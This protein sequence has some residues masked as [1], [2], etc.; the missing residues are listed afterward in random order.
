MN[1]IVTFIFLLCFLLMFSSTF[2][3]AGALAASVLLIISVILIILILKRNSELQKHNLKEND[4]EKLI[5]QNVKA[6]GVIRILNLE[7][8]DTDLD[9]KCVSRNLYMEGDYSWYELKCVN[10]DGQI[11]WIDIE[12]DD[13]LLVS[14]VLKKLQ[15]QELK[16][17]GSLQDIDENEY[18]AVIYNGTSFN[19]IDSGDAVFYKR[20]DNANKEKLY[21]WDFQKG[22]KLVSVEEWQNSTGKSDMEYFYSQIINPASII[23]Y[24]ISGEN[25]E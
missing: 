17:S 25:Y 1:L 2:T 23:V 11:F 5:I 4:S 24:S 22:N 13:E 6:G 3:G 9:L 8:F 18:G 7:G 21:Y 19:Y 20:C 15:A 10:A 12:D 16:F 14:V